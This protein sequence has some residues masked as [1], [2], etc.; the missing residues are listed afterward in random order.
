MT[1]VLPAGLI[2]VSADNGGT[3]SAGVVTWANLPAI[4]SGASV[5]L[6]VTTAVSAVAA[7]GTLRNWAEISSDSGDDED[8]QPDTD[9]TDDEYTDIDDLDDSVLDNFDGTDEDDNDDAEIDVTDVVEPSDYDLALAKIVND[10]DGVVQAG[11]NVSWTIRVT[12]QGDAAS[13]AYNVTDTLPS[14]LTFVSA[15]NGGTAVNGVVTWSNLPSIPAGATF[16]LHIVTKVGAVGSYRNWAEISAD[17]GDDVD[18]TPDTDIAND[19]YVGTDDLDRPDFGE[20]DHDDALITVTKDPGPVTGGSTDGLMLFAGF[21]LI[22]GLVMKRS[23]RRRM[24]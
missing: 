11:S 22:A 6:T 5:D 15:D 21:A 1:D 24:A 17:S 13:G 2:F 9:V 20:D 10:A 8:S 4:A 3:E 18:S 16:D 12:N 23:A 19:P 14:G 7:G